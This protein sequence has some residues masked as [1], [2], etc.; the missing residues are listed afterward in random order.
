MAMELLN[1]ELMAPYRGGLFKQEWGEFSDTYLWH[2]T[3]ITR[4]GISGSTCYIKVGLVAHPSEIS[5]RC[6]PYTYPREVTIY[7]EWSTYT[8]AADGLMI[9]HDGN[10]TLMLYPSTH[11]AK[12]LEQWLRMPSPPD[13]VD[14]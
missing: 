1:S 2:I 5:H 3:H 6:S 14:R 12:N 4:Y 8:K 7:P 11:Q 13:A 9:I 10:R